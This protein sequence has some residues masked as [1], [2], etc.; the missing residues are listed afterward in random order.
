MN[1]SNDLWNFLFFILF[2]FLQLLSAS[3]RFN[4]IKLSVLLVP[5]LAVTCDLSSPSHRSAMW[6]GN[7]FNLNYRQKLT[8]DECIMKCSEYHGLPLMFQN[9]SA[10]MREIKNATENEWN[11][12]SEDI[13]LIPSFYIQAH[14]DFQ[15][16]IWYSSFGLKSKS[17]RIFTGQAIRTSDPFTGQTIQEP[18]YKTKLS[19]KSIPDS[20][21]HDSLDPDLPNVNYPILN[22]RKWSFQ[23]F[24]ILIFQKP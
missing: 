12:T 16:S 14:Y 6:P 2:W 11:Y 21:W 15:K 20:L 8:Y 22:D 23:V 5:W 24:W 4:A 1:L 17:S 9:F 3:T 7:T 18:W 19:S 13:S 10:V